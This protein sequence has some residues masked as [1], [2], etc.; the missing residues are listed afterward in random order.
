MKPRGVTR[1]EKGIVIS[2]CII[3]LA[4]IGFAAYGFF[5]AD[6]RDTKCNLTIIKE[7]ND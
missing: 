2:C 3:V 7:P 4:I 5:V 6:K 1:F